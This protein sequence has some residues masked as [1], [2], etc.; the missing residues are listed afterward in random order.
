[1]QI[2][3]RQV[4]QDVR[5]GLVEMDPLLEDGLIVVMQRQAGADIGA[6]TLEGA[7]RLDREQVMAALE[8]AVL[9]RMPSKCYSNWPNDEAAN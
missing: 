4:V 3:F 7:V 9:T 6:G 2:T 1:L 5:I 8:G